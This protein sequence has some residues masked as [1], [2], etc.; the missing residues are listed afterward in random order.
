MKY[1][2][3]EYAAFDPFMDSDRDVGNARMQKISIVK[4][5]KVQMCVSLSSGSHE[6]P[7]GTMARFEKS[8]LP[9]CEAF[10]SYYMCIECCDREMVPDF[11]KDK[12]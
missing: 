1:T 9:Y 6:I 11:W 10:G 3:E 7:S 12:D 2:T 4:T 8:Y 5:R